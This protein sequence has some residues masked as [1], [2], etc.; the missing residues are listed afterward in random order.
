[1]SVILEGFWAKSVVIGENMIK[2]VQEEDKKGW[3]EKY[4]RARADYI[5]LE[6]RVKKQQEEFLKFANS[7]LITKFLPIL[8][9][10]E[11][12]A[13]AGDD[14]GLSL[15]LKNFWKVLESEGV[16]E[17]KVEVGDEFDSSIMECTAAEGGGEEAKVSKVLRK[18][19]RLKDKVL[20]PTQV[21]V[22]GKDV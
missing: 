12:A 20:R 18:G 6:K 13:H 11:R 14:N 10:L 4:K 16:K 2:K 22:G 19:Y 5:N 15:L 3:E 7:V 21:G 1:M 17:I 8:D 9:D